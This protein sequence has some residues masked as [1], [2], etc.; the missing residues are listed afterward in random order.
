MALDLESAKFIAD[1]A[2][3]GASFDK[4]LTIGRQVIMLSQKELNFLKKRSRI[5]KKSGIMNSESMPRYSDDFF[6][7]LGAK[8]V[9][10]LDASDYEGASIIFD[11]NQPLKGQ[12]KQF[13]IVF[14]GGSLEHI[15]NI[16]VVMEN[17]IK[18]VKTGGRFIGHIPANNYL[19]HGFYQ[20]SPEFFFKVFSQENGFSIEQL[21]LIEYSPI[22]KLFVVKDP[23]MSQSSAH[24]M[25]KYHLYIYI[26]A[27][28][29]KEVKC[30]KKWPT[31]Q[32]YNKMWGQKRNQDPHTSVFKKVGSRIKQKMLNHVPFLAR[33]IDSVYHSSLNSMYSLRNKS[34]FRRL[35]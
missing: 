24:T 16:P 17:Y 8:E 12:K 10:S 30:F 5:L 13:D 32:V 14:D 28:K 26:Q 23:R 2:D 7:A 21:V 9:D 20:F 1:A 31:Q 35:K 15:F 33:S 4:C 29:N 34:L 11:L 18:L 3:K 25:N 19:G 22:K 6:K 27:R